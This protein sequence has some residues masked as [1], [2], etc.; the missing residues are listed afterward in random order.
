MASD[1]KPRRRRRDPR[2]HPTEVFRNLYDPWSIPMSDE[3]GAPQVTCLHDGL[4]WVQI[5]AP[6]RFFEELADK[7]AAG[8][9]ADL[10]KWFTVWAMPRKEPDPSLCGAPTDKGIPCHFSRP[11]PHHPQHRRPT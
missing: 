7:L 9:T 2:P 5:H 3:E 4:D 11:C 10:E 1:D 8:D 6:R